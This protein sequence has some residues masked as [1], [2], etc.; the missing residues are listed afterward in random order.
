MQMV[1]AAVKLK[2]TCSLEEKLW[3]TRQCIRKQR[4]YFAHKGPSSQSYGFSS[5]HI[6]TWELD[7]KEGWAPKNWCFQTVVQEKTLKNPLDSKEITPVNPKGN[8]LWIFFGRTDA[9]A[10]TQY[11]GHVMQ[12]AESL[13][14]TLRLGK[15][16][17]RKRR[18]WQ[19]MRWLDG[20]TNSMDMDLGG[21]RELVM[22]RGLAC[23]SSWGCKE[24][25]TTERLNWTELL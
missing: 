24:L 18:W 25:D 12:R 8:Q 5:N 14:K 10:E 21:L 20:T 4:H 9:E 2:D 7:H 19:R 15:I 16:E 22:D 13:E 3:P 23:C 1:T 17:G 11:F 6:H